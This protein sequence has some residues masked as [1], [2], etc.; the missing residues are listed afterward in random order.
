MLWV[1]FAFYMGLLLCCLG[2]T[3]YRWHSLSKA[4]SLI[5][6]L[7]F[8]T[9]VQ[10][11]IAMYFRLTRH[12]NF[13]TYHIYTPIELSVICFYFILSF[14]SK[15][16]YWIAGIL[17]TISCALSILN[18]IYLQPLKTF[19]S[20]YLLFEGF[21]IITLCLLSFYKILI[22]DD[23]SPRKM[24]HFWL[25]ISF[26]FYWS[27][28]Y[29]DFGLIGKLETISPKLAEVFTYSLSTANILF[30]LAVAI[31]FFFYKKLIPS[32]E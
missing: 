16:K 25:T 22:R 21:T 32:G 9:L 12:N 5:C 30:Y 27:L 11:S 3:F 18:T 23:V 17:T 7:L 10:E 8:L 6:F 13:P 20:Y 19:N 26:L 29:V 2:L 24:A 4:D 15:Y 31:V 1:S 14:R 28:T